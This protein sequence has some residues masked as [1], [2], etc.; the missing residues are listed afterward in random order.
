MIVVSH[1]TTIQV[2]RRHALQVANTPTYSV[3][4]RLKPLLHCVLTIHQ[5]YRWTDGRHA[6]SM[7]EM[8]YN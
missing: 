6:R 1:D 4:C 5:R 3:I 2:R 8:R 7:S